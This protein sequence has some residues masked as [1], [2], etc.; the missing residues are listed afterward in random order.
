ML[1]R[2]NDFW[3]VFIFFEMKEARTR[4]VEYLRNWEM[5]RKLLVEL[6]SVFLSKLGQGIHENWIFLKWFSR[7]NLRWHLIELMDNPKDGFYPIQT[8][9]Q[10]GNSVGIIWARIVEKTVL[11]FDEGFEPNS[12]NYCD[13]RE[14]TFFECYKFQHHSFK[15]KCI[16]IHDNSIV[17]YQKLP[18]YF[19]TVKDLTVEKIIKWSPSSPV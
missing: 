15:V 4:C 8:C 9:R 1:K 13:F 19:L 11:E 12:P 5:S 16:F 2:N 14:Q 17:M 18:V 6:H 3:A 7:N 10:Q